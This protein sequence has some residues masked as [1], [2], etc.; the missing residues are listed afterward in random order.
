MIAKVRGRL[1]DCEVTERGHARGLGLVADR[2]PTAG[3]VQDGPS[4][5]ATMNGLD[6]PP[7]RHRLADEGERRGI[8]V[9]GEAGVVAVQ[10]RFTPRPI[11]RPSSKVRMIAGRRA[12][13]QV[14]RRRDRPEVDM[15][16]A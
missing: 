3:S 12:R 7:G 5:L 2:T 15:S 14:T 11:A 16:G 13:R 9:E 6:R 4:R 8:R 1:P 10:Y